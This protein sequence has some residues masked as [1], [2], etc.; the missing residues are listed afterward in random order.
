M[1]AGASKRGS[2]TAKTSRTCAFSLCLADVRPRN[3]IVFRACGSRGH[4]DRLENHATSR[5]SETPALWKLAAKAFTWLKALETIKDRHLRAPSD[6][7][8]DL[9]LGGVNFGIDP[10]YQYPL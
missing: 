5:I 3:G 4:E 7:L 1:L 10:L 9:F 8:E 2:S 6:L